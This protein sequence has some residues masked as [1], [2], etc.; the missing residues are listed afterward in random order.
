MPIAINARGAAGAMGMPIPAAVCVHTRGKCV[1]AEIGV[2]ASRRT[3]PE[4]MMMMYVL[5]FSVLKYHAQKFDNSMI[6]P[7]CRLW[8]CVVQSRR[9]KKMSPRDH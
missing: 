3:T 9:P 1:N 4:N 7:Y 6:L 8:Q 5:S 2:S